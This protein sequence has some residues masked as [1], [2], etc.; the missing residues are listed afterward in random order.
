LGVAAPS[1]AAATAAAAAIRAEWTAGSG[2]SART[3]FAD[4]KTRV[5]DSNQTPFVAGSVDAALA[6]GE[7]KTDGEYTVAY[8]AHAPLEPR[9][10]QAEWR[11]G[12]LTAWTRTQRARGVPQGLAHPCPAPTDR[13][14]VI[15][16]D[17][18]A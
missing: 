15:M 4:L 10:A 17:T 18:G 3:L 8:I 2:A 16:P 11:G 7:I 6:S 1:A 9:A 5:E 13:A 14:R 12:A